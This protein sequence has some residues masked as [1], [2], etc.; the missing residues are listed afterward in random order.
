MNATVIISSVNRKDTLQRLLGNLLNQTVQPEEIIIIEAGNH[1]LDK[2]EFHVQ[3]A[4]RLTLCHAPKESLAASRERGRLLAKSEILIYFDDDVISPL[5]YIETVTTHFQLKQNTIAIGGIYK[6][7][8]TT[9]RRSWSIFVGR[10]FGI[11]GNGHRNKILLSGWTDYVR[12]I[13]AEHETDAEWLFGCNWAIRANAFDNPTVKI[14]TGLLAWSFLEDVMLGYKITKA[15]GICMRILPSLGVVHD[16]IASSG[17][18]STATVRMRILYRH[19]F[20]KENLSTSGYFPATKF[21]LGMVANLLLMLKQKREIWV[22]RECFLSLLFI[23][24]N[25]NTNLQAANE[26]IFS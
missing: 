4:C 22:I 5:N 24:G 14:E 17:G 11:Y 9:D 23:M 2:Q 19:L 13:H 3:P 25:K 7:K 8:T 21:N 12:G 1:P 16:P 10:L 15:Y 18:I 26:F 6:D 20:W